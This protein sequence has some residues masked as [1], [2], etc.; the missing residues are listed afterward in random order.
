L[1][2]LGG[3]WRQREA[4]RENDREPNQPHAAGESSET[5]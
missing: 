1:L 4:E 5:S 2:P 3:E